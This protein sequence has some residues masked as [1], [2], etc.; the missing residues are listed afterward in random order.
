MITY[1]WKGLPHPLNVID[2][3]AQNAST[4]PTGGSRSW[5]VCAH[6]AIQLMI[7]RL[8]C[9]RKKHLGL[10]RT[11]CSMVDGHYTPRQPSTLTRSPKS[12]CHWKRFH[13]IGTA[14]QAELFVY[15]AF[16]LVLV[17][18]FS[19]CQSTPQS[20]RDCGTFV[21]NLHAF[22]DENDVRRDGNGPWSK[23]SSS[24]R[25]YKIDEQTQ[26]AIRVD[27]A[28]K[29]PPNNDYTIQVAILCI[30]NY[31]IMSILFLSGAHQAI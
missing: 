23:P 19:V 16:L 17:A 15:F 14:I 8:P 9:C 11:P 20:F 30:V 24:S 27:H 3:D 29:V 31:E 10:M 1:E 12:F 13:E 4:R 18:A 25:Y 26:E 6:N 5:E 22:D 7:Y 2:A 21:I 28:G